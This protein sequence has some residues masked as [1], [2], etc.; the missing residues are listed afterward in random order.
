MSQERKNAEIRTENKHLME[1]AREYIEHMQENIAGIRKI[2][3]VGKKRGVYLTCEVLG[4]CGERL[5]TCG[6]N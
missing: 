5:T 6:R 3:A 4:T 1:H 2:N